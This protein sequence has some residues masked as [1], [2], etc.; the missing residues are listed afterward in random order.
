MAGAGLSKADVAA[1]IWL[2]SSI[3]IERFPASAHPDPP[4]EFIVREG[5]V[6]PVAGPEQIFVIVVGGPEPTHATVIPSHPSCYP[7]TSPVR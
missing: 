1:E 7:V 5:R 4:Y 6:Y 3:P 2:R